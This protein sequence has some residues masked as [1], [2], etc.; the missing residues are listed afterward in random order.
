MLIVDGRDE[1]YSTGSF[2]VSYEPLARI[3]KGAGAY[4]AINLDGGGSSTFI[5]RES[6]NVFS[7]HNKP[8][9]AGRLERQVLDGLAVVTRK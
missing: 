6:D 5:V 3:L 2:S 1:L 8:G 7:M 9:N 4:D